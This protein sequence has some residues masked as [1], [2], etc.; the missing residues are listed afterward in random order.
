MKHSLIANAGDEYGLLPLWEAIYGIYDEFS[1]ICQKYGLRHY[2][3]AGTLLGAVRHNGFI[4]W[5]DDLDIAMPRPDYEK[6]IALAEEELP[7]HLRFFNWK[8]MP[9]FPMMFGKIQETRESVVLDMEKKLGRMLSNGIYIDIFPLD[10][11]TRRNKI[12]IQLRDALLLPIERFRMYK[13]SELSKRGKSAWIVGMIFAWL[14]PWLRTPSDFFKIHEKTLLRGDFDSSEFVAECSL[15]YNLFRRAPLRRS[16]WGEAK[17]HTFNGK[18]IMIPSDPDNILR[19][20]FGE[21]YMSL[22]PIEKRHPTH[23]YG[24]RCSWWLGPKSSDI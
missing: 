19:C 16:Y 5:D 12:W 13:Y 17:P 3:L 2:A 18:T 23:G 22:P 15:S 14:I 11:Y 4:P 1:K 10:G 8:N 6:F 7:R 24:W 20:Y 9:D 21:D